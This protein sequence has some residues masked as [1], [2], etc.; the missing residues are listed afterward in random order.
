[1]GV[2]YVPQ[3]DPSKPANTANLILRVSDELELTRKDAEIIVA[4]VLH[5]LVKLSK[6]FAYLKLRDFGKFAFRPMVRRKMRSL[7][8]EM[9]DV[10]ARERFCFTSTPRLNRKP[11][12]K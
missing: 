11:G 8:G 3:T 9:R 6:E 2:R 1:M 10:P 7:S 12:E 5:N 4:C